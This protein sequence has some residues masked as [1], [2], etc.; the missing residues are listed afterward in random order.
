M[1]P[2][3]DRAAEAQGTEDRAAVLLLV[4]ARFQR[5]SWKYSSIAY[6]FNLKDTGALFQTMNLV[7]TA[8]GLAPCAIGTGD[9][10]LFARITGIAFEEEGTVGEFTLR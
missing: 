8:M 5:V 2:L 4:T 6:A 7:A 1:A 9:T 3:L 10:E